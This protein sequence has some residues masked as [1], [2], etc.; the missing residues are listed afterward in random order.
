MI[1]AEYLD[2]IREKAAS[3]ARDVMSRVSILPLTGKDE[4][5]EK[6]CK[7]REKA[8]HDFVDVQSRG[9]AVDLTLAGESI[10]TVDIIV[11]AVDRSQTQKF[12]TDAEY[13]ISVRKHTWRAFDDV[14]EASR[15]AL[16]VHQFSAEGLRRLGHC[17]EGTITVNRFDYKKLEDVTETVN[18]AGIDE[19]V[20]R[21]IA[22]AQAN[23]EDE[24]I[25]E[26]IGF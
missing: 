17:C 16:M 14:D 7:I 5:V 9:L 21:L 4:D 25:V 15:Y 23:H 2:S 22:E 26:A 13:W 6:A 8:V 20:D 10:L 1:K 11:W 19:Y 12:G 24:V 3:I 18:A